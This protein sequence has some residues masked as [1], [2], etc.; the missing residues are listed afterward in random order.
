MKRQYFLYS[1]KIQQCNAVCKMG[2]NDKV[3]KY[4]EEKSKNIY[5]WSSFHSLNALNLLLL[6]VNSQNCTHYFQLWVFAPSSFTLSCLHPSSLY[7]PTFFCSLLLLHAEYRAGHR[8][9]VSSLRREEMIF[10]KWNRDSMSCC[11]S[12]S[13]ACVCVRAHVSVRVHP[14]VRLRVNPDR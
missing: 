13:W 4:Q 7:A 10:R 3:F 2:S 1:G 5:A 8:R 14:H 6:Y 12:G 9:T 11:A